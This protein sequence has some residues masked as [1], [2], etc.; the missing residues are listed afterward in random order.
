MI[1]KTLLITGSIAIV[2][3]FS[4]TPLTLFEPNTVEAQY[5]KFAIM[6]PG[7]RCGER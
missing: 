1:L 4:G 7:G 6:G 5:V 3:G 2:V